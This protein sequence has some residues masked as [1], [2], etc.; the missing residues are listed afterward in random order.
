MAVSVGRTSACSSIGTR[1]RSGC[2]LTQRSQRLGTS[3]QKFSSPS[4]LRAGLMVWFLPSHI[5]LSEKWRWKADL[6][7]QPSCNS[8]GL[9]SWKH[10]FVK[11]TIKLR[12]LQIIMDPP[13]LEFL[14]TK[15]TNDNLAHSGMIKSGIQ[16]WRGD[17]LCQ[18]TIVPKQI[19]RKHIQTVL[20]KSS[21]IVFLRLLSKSRAWVQHSSGS[22]YLA[23][24][25]IKERLI[26]DL[27]GSMYSYPSNVFIH[28]LLHFLCCFPTQE[29]TGYIFL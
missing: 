21:P 8:L 4:Q 5:F 26:N 13:Y 11:V 24:S 27:Y 16:Q 23:G 22:H 10:I 7:I 18:H 6:F 17:T 2:P 14:P 15:E 20:S 1:E 3:G 19:H 28:P 9:P 12:F 29:T 25:A